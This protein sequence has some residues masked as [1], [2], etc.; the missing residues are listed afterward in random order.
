MRKIRWI[1]NTAA[2]CGVAIL[3][4]LSGRLLHYLLMNDTESYTRIMMHELYG[5]QENIDVLFVGSS[6]CYYSLD[7]AVTDEI[8]GM[9]TFNAGSSAQ[10]LD[11][12]LA[13]IREA[14]Q[15]N[16]LKQVYLDVYYVLAQKERYK[17]RYSL[18]STYAIADYMKPSLRKVN[19][20]LE[21]S[22]SDYYM[23]SFVPIR[24]NWKQVFDW[25]YLSSVLVN[26][27]KQAYHD[28]ELVTV[29]NDP[30]TYRQKGFIY[31]E[32]RITDGGFYASTHYDSVSKR[33][34]SA[35]WKSSLE[36]IIDYC[37][38]N[39]IQL[40]LISTPMPDFRLMDMGDYDTY[41][42][43]VRA[44]IAGTGVEFYDFSLCRAQWFEAN[45]SDF[46][47]GD[48]LSGEGAEKF[49]E[50][51]ARFF[52]GQIPKEE[53][54]YGSYAQ[55]AADFDTRVFGLIINEDL[56]SQ[57]VSIE[58]VT[59]ADA[60]DVTYSVTKIP[61]DLS[62]G[63]EEVEIPQLATAEPFSY[64]AGETGTLAITAFYDGEETNHVRFAYGIK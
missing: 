36:Q 63:A 54:F 6:H 39:G 7:T 51:F 3:F 29:H 42:D 56:D 38:G 19:Y 33:E 55:K 24:R 59:N 45:D 37:A 2:V 46:K 15:Y 35:D 49:S 60:E 27:Q 14:E 26:K 31:D 28:Y 48:H 44:L 32:S 10:E 50:L 47:D 52:T 1:R 25:N 62:T 18:V 41:I 40:T 12:S 34:I 22:S 23:N 17:D 5:Q 21:A 58:P 30:K 64:P 43:Q 11:G 9:N 16:Q 61:D 53:L 8:F 13:L 4:C 20:L 57:E